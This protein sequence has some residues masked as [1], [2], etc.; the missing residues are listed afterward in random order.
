MN[1]KMYISFLA[2]SMLFVM[3]TAI[4]PTSLEMNKPIEIIATDWDGC[5][6]PNIH[7]ARQFARVLRILPAKAI[8][9]GTA[10]N[11]GT[12]KDMALYGLYDEQGNKLVS[13]DSY[14]KYFIHKSQ[15]LKPYELPIIKALSQGP[16]MCD[17]IKV[18]QEEQKQG[19]LV[20]VWTNRGTDLNASLNHVN[21]KLGELGKP[22]FEPDGC[23][24]VGKTGDDASPVGKRN[25][26]YFTK[27]FNHL[28]KVLIQKGLNPDKI[29]RIDF[30]DDK[31]E[32]LAVFDAW[33]KNL[34]KT[35][36]SRAILHTQIDAEFP[37]LYA[38]ACNGDN[39]L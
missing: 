7:P 21:E 11:L 29:K 2:L 20:F 22:T 3:H 33:T 16:P 38:A 15:S 28:K 5:C 32:L 18:L 13:Y 23:F 34:P 1:K 9:M 19:K 4:K 39:E 31:P 25:P 12:I 36:Q 24:V 27:A 17:T 14:V 6:T 8:V 30:I 37:H 35:I 26:E 10:Q